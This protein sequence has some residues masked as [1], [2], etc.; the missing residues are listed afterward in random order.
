MVHDFEYNVIN[1]SKI[2]QFDCGESMIFCKAVWF[3]ST[4]SLKTLM[5]GHNNDSSFHNGST[6]FS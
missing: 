1:R 5:L 3:C 4:C 2:H 6:I